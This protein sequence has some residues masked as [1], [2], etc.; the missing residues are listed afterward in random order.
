MK[1]AIIGGGPIGL[2]FASLC[3]KNQID[4][5]VFEA[6]EELGGQITQLYPKKIV[7]NIPGIDAIVA[8]DY[9]KDLVDQIN[10]DK[11]KL[12]SKITSIT[13]LS[14]Y[15]YIINA[16]GRGGFIPRKLTDFSD[17]FE[18][19]V[20]NIR[21][22]LKNYNFLTGQDVVI[23]GGGDSALDWAKQLSEICKVTLVHR[24][25]EFRGNAET[26]SGCGLRV[27][28]PYIYT[29]I[30]VSKFEKTVRVSKVGEPDTFIDIP[31]DYIFVN[32]GCD[33]QPVNFVGESCII[34]KVGDCAGT[35][36]IAAGIAQANQTFEEITNGE[37]ND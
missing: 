4:Y 36:T 14:Q 26:I 24:R 21:Y 11:V 37:A 13:D 5:T 33:L 6:A 23:F 7:T 34:Y 1:I 35:T 32:F 12:G 10:L 9:I 2:Y 28:K 8:E 19:D 27:L 15:S 17:H 20:C 16:T 22:S 31:Y 25:T 3:Q 30:D 29:G 18:Q